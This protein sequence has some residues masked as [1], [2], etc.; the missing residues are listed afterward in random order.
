MTRIDKFFR[1]YY[2]LFIFSIPLF[3]VL[4]NYN[5]YFGL[6]SLGQSG[7]FL[8]IHII[9]FTALFYLLKLF[10]R[11]AAWSLLLLMIIY[12]FF[13]AA[14]DLLKSVPSLKFFAT[15]K[16]LLPLLGLLVL[17]ILFIGSRLQ[18]PPWNTLMYFNLLFVIFLSYEIV[19][20]ILN[21]SFHKDRSN[22]FSQKEIISLNLNQPIDTARLPDIYFIVLDEYTSSD[23][24]KTEFNYDNSSIDSIFSQNHFYVSTKSSSNYNI[25][26]FSISSTLNLDFLKPDLNGKKMTAKLILQGLSTMQNCFLPKFLDNYGYE[27]RNLS[28]Y[29]LN[30]YDPPRPELFA[31]MKKNVLRMGTLYGRI[32][33]DISY[34][35]YSRL[36]LTKK[37]ILDKNFN[38]ERNNQVSNNQNCLD[39]LNQEIENNVSKP[40]FVYCHVSLPHE[41]FY[42]DRN[43]NFYSDSTQRQ[44]TNKQLY[45]E[46]LQF[47][48]K[49]LAKLIPKI[50][51]TRSRPTV[52]IIEGDH[53]FR[54]YDELKNENDIFRNL[55]AYYFSDKDYRALYDHISPVNSF[56]VILN[57]YFHT[58]LHLLTDSSV[59][60][61]DRVDL[62]H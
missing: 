19:V 55:N 49:Q 45:L 16:F 10:Y 54:Y 28:V 15:Y 27:I 30:R 24:L 29:R 53:G 52:A 13:G 42:V 3:Y 7:Q 36:P 60:I 40:R 23:C 11:N 43:G 62:Y 46:Q 25:T 51:Q 6:L 39:L 5:E 47:V 35:V 32:Q 58:Q 41:P 2:W 8:L 31:P 12:F 17:A 4:H 26:P 38:E 50:N 57:K 1:K 21:I 34:A 59:F 9:V 48:N 20:L 61:N 22:N 37:W 56:R 18:N 33:R 44:F 14:H